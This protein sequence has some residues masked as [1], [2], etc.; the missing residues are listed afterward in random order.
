[1]NE[2]LAH[3]KIGSAEAPNPKLTFQDHDTC[4]WHD[5]I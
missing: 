4:L 1:M 5:V 2:K 3:F